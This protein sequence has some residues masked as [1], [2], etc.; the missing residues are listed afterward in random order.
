MTEQVLAARTRPFLPAAFAAALAG[1]YTMGAFQ[2]D[3]GRPAAAVLFIPPG[4]VGA[5]QAFVTARCGRGPDA[6]ELVRFNNE[7]Q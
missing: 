4:E 7:D 3:A 2:D 6:A 5:V 1:R